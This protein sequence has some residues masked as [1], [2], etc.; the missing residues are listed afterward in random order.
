MK[1]H[2]H[3]LGY[4]HHWPLFV[5]GGTVES[6]PA[7]QCRVGV[8]KAARPGGTLE[9]RY[10]MPPRVRNGS[11]CEA[12]AGLQ[13][14]TCEALQA[15]LRDA[16]KGEPV[17]GTEVPGYS[18]S[19]LPGRRQG[20][21]KHR[22]LWDSRKSLNSIGPKSTF[23]SSGR[24]PD[25][26]SHG[27]TVMKILSQFIALLFL[28]G[29]MG[30][31][32]ADSTQISIDAG[33]PGI[34]ISPMLY[35]IFFE[36]INR[37]GDGGLYAEMVQNRSFEDFNLPMGWTLLNEGGSQVSL[38]VDRSQPL[39][40]K[41]PSSLRLE[42]ASIG[43]GGRAGVI[44]QGYKGLQIKSKD[45]V[46][47]PVPGDSQANP[48]WLKWM[49]QFAAA[50]SRPENG[51]PVQTGK[52]YQ[53]SLYAR[54][55]GNFTGPLTVSLEKQDGTL[56]ATQD[57][58]H[59]ESGWKKFDFTL[60]PAMT[61]SNARLVISAKAPGTV[62][63]D[64]VSLFPADTFNQRPN[65][66]R[67]DLMKM[68][69]ELQPAFVRFP[70]GSFGE[71]HLLSE[72]FRWKET[73]GDLAERPGQWNIWGYRTTN[74]L[75]YLEY[76]QMCED[77]KAEP[78]WVINCGMAEKEFA[79]MEKLD[80]WIQD[81]LDSIEYANG[82]IESKWGGLRAKAG[83]PQPFHLKFLEIGNEN[84]MSYSWGGGNPREYADRYLPFHEKLKAS[85]PDLRYI[86]TAPIQKFPINAP[87][88]ILD[89]HYYPTAEWFEDHAA[90][91]DNYDR[92]GPKIYV[93][94]YATKKGAGNGNLKAALGEAAFM[95]GME[96]NSDLVLM[97][98]Y[99]PLFANPSWR[100][101]NPNLIVFD[102]IRAYG[103]PSYYNQLLFATNRPDVILPLD[104][105]LPAGSDP[106]AR[107]PLY[108]VAGLKQDT[109]EIIIKVVNIGGKPEPASFHLTDGGSWM[110][111]ST[112]LSS[113]H[114]DDENSFDLPTKVAPRKAVIGTLDSHFDFIFEPYSITVLR[115]KKN[116]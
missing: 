35:G 55:Q 29:G 109:G 70:A 106:K 103:T 83:H 38:A 49:E 16:T 64:M 22:F 42:F 28:W 15:S 58:P 41:N 20:H 88:E 104:L 36:D 79:P 112:V 102:S 34:T 52:S 12:T 72:A 25:F 32:Q 57:I 115:L 85:N 69:V 82:P 98:S 5:P 97:A 47:L 84:G 96:R 90:M 94:E 73:I 101:W 56:L 91:Y 77:L 114:P 31:V 76:L 53:L 89:E 14:R 24:I 45:P 6:S 50:Q 23:L 68:L 33:K 27:M 105:Q 17:P 71:G 2:S 30:L 93:G 7:L 9:G 11:S 19:S 54:A 67:P 80:P 95:T 107:K 8:G 61:E 40:E 66:L 100:E 1:I 99:A 3:P 46:T 111:D 113:A 39:N 92:R 4:W 86:A 60:K 110:A 18:Q 37:S 81:A 13:E 26:L 108:A 48:G 116:S 63:I 21:Q 87:V 75:G 65:G 62:W 78:L 10:S 51:L 59:L 74:G 44:N 43:K